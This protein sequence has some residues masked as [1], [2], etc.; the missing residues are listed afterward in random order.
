LQG[1]LSTVCLIIGSFDKNKLVVLGCGLI[2]GLLAL[3]KEKNQ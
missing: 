3:K 1:K 2:A